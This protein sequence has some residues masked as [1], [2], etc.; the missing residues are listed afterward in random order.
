MALIDQIEMLGESVDGGLIGL[1]EA[2]DLLAGLSGGRLTILGARDVIAN[3]KGARER[4]ERIGRCA[5]R[6]VDL[7]TAVQ[8]A[9]DD[10][11]RELRLAAARAEMDQG[12]AE[13]RSAYRRLYGGGSR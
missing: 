2:A 13:M 5:G 10:G 9:A 7:L 1:E 11:E 6:M 4:Y 12:L 8:N 3:H